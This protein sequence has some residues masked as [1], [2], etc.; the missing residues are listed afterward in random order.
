MFI[1]TIVCVKQYS[2]HICRDPRS[3]KA[4]VLDNTGPTAPVMDFPFERNKTYKTFGKTANH[5]TKVP[6]RD[7]VDMDKKFRDNP[8]GDVDHFLHRLNESSSAEKAIEVQLTEVAIRQAMDQANPEFRDLCVAL[9]SVELLSA[10]LQVRW[11]LSSLCGC[12]LVA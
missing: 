3:S 9:P 2:P 12:Y 11:R 4:A 10:L 1:F 7:I 6:L 5:F 8:D